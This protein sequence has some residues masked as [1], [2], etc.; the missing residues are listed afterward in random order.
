MKSDPWHKAYG[1]VESWCEILESIEYRL[2]HW[3]KAPKK[4]PLP[5]TPSE[6]WIQEHYEVHNIADGTCKGRW[7]I[8]TPK[9]TKHKR[10]K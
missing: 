9:K 10:R 3:G 7:R 5:G 6:E 8:L 4:I 2:T 1:I